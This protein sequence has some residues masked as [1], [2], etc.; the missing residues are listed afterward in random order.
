MPFYGEMA[1]IPPVFFPFFLKILSL[2]FSDRL[3]LRGAKQTLNN[4][5]FNLRNIS[6]R[7]K[8]LRAA[9]VLSYLI[10]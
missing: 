8:M 4:V 7:I 3:N 2:S 5:E 1:L 6:Q 10:S 9:A